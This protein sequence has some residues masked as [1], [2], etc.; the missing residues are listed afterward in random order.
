M[1][2][3]NELRGL[4][5]AQLEEMCDSGVLGADS[6]RSTSRLYASSL[7]RADFQRDA[8]DWYLGLADAPPRGGR[9]VVLTSGP[10]GAGKSTLVGVDTLSDYRRLDADRLKDHLI[11]RAISD[12]IYQDLLDTQLVDGAP[13]APRELA[14]LVHN[15]ST[16][17]MADI[18]KICI[19]RHENVIVEATL[20]WDDHGPDLVERFA[21]A[22]YSTMRVL[23]LD[24]PK[25]LAQEQA[26]SRWWE[27]RTDWIGK[28]NR[29]GGR[30][31][32]PSAIESCFNIDGSS[33]CVE[34]A[35]KLHA[36]AE[37]YDLE[38]KLEMYE[39]LSIGDTVHR[40]ADE[41]NA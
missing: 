27:G 22:E 17:L 15:E 21:A 28:T 5:A 9:T 33:K 8:L 14:A 32:P 1:I 39:R 10:P 36:A 16:T 37:P 19:Q 20:R 13:I 38:I 25:A 24:V 18:T 26:L 2:E 7:A 30:F 40:V 31:M 34:N 41:H 29:L 4:V 35:R 12:G 6:E 3:N 23:S 11:D